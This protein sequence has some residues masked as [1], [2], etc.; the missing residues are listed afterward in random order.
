MNR[1]VENRPKNKEK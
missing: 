1:N